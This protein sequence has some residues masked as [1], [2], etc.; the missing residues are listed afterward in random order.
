MTPY[1]QTTADCPRA[2]FQLN[3]TTTT[4]RKALALREAYAMEE[5]LKISLG[6]SVEEEAT[7]VLSVQL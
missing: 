3:M 6:H 1:E 5:G 7:T 4:D 2:I